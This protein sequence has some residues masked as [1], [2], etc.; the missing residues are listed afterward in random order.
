MSVATPRPLP[1]GSGATP[2]GE[3]S[4]RTRIARKSVAEPTPERET[5]F[6]EFFAGVLR[7]APVLIGAAIAFFGLRFFGI[8][9]GPLLVFIAA[10]V[11]L[12]FTLI[13]P[14]VGLY[15]LILN[16][17]NELD[18]YYKLQRILPISLPILFDGAVAFGIARRLTS[19]H[20]VPRI[21][22]RQN[23]LLLAYAVMVIL[24][25]IVSDVSQP[26]LWAKFRSGFL[27][28]PIIYLFMIVLVQTRRDLYRL[29][30]VIF[31]A[32]SL[33]MVGAM[34][35]YIQKGGGAYRVSGTVGAINYLSYVCI[36]ILPI[37]I[38]LVAYFRRRGSRLVILA[39]AIITLFVSLQT[40]SRSGY[41]A[42]IATMGFIGY[43]FVRRPQ[44]LV[45]AVVFAAIFY[46]LIPTALTERL[47]SSG[48]I[49]ESSRWALSKV[50]LMMALDNPVLGVGHHAYEAKF[51]DYNVD[52]VFTEPKA[53]HS[54]YF[55]I[56]ATTGFPALF[57]YLATFGLSFLQ[58]SGIIRHYERTGQTR[59]FGYL[60]SL[61][62]Q[63]GLIGHFVFGLAGS[64]GDSYYAY[65]LL[66]LSV[67]LIR[68]H[69]DGRHFVP[70]L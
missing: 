6:E 43:R 59:A 33:L 44:L 22:M 69:R 55:A 2:S 40:L 66:G 34:S 29:L 36:V 42:L 50:G 56:A 54:L 39:L 45:V 3:G 64:Y 14:E 65:M 46:Q 25:V 21:D 61:G 70:V 27:I 10:A 31:F 18:S 5:T 47:T 38:S 15:A 37:L 7:L 57:L 48:D 17:V 67:V 11:S 49:T 53:P 32:E 23:W 58:L 51:L 52:N 35:D 19:R 13:H 20:W 8:R 28:R 24:S 1:S 63:G 26:N 4:A 9:P 30:V 16:F 68:L 12:P 41:Y 60:L 62:V